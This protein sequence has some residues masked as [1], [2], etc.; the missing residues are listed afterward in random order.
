MI[1]WET[2]ALAM[3][4]DVKREAENGDDEMAH[5]AEDALTNHV[6]EGIASGKCPDPVKY[7]KLALSTSELSFSRWCA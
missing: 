5:S 3:L 4:E 1:P 2:T 7:A 6:L